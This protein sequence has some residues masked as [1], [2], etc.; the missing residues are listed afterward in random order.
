MPRVSRKR[1]APQAPFNDVVVG[2]NRPL[3]T[4][5]PA[6]EVSCRLH[7]VYI[8]IDPF[9]R[10]E[11]IDTDIQVFFMKAGVAGGLVNP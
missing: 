10:Y 3:N 2:R 7:S 1:I 4:A 9:L 11:T 8:W 6:T 5:S